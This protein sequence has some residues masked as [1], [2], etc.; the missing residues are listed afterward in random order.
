MTSAGF[1]Y[2]T[3]GHVSSISTT[4]WRVSSW[5]VKRLSNEAFCASLAARYAVCQ[6]VH[7]QSSS[8]I[9]NLLTI[10]VASCWLRKATRQSGFPLWALSTAMKVY[11]STWLVRV[12]ALGLQR[13]NWPKQHRLLLSDEIVDLTKSLS[14]LS[15]HRV[16]YWCYWAFTASLS[17]NFPEHLA[18]ESYEAWAACASQ[19]DPRYVYW[20]SIKSS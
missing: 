1:F 6:P 2:W 12:T 3:S 4:K 17:S 8:A 15:K 18:F 7:P 13:W 10:F 16:L 14:W 5:C 20:S 9:K 11:A 19:P